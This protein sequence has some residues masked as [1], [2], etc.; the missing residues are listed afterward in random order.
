MR[1]DEGVARM[2]EPN[3]APS[4]RMSAAA[5][6]TPS[7]A[8][9]RGYPAAKQRGSLSLS[10]AASGAGTAP[11]QTRQPPHDGPARGRR[12]DGAGS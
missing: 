10:A 1:L 9:S 8:G 12:S 6:G 7:R 11:S 2:L 4:D 3:A 5:D